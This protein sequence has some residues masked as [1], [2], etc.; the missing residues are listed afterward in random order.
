MTPGCEWSRRVE[1]HEVMLPPP[2]PQ[3]TFD[4]LYRVTPWHYPHIKMPQWGVDVPEEET[5]KT[6]ADDKFRQMWKNEMTRAGR[7]V[8]QSPTLPGARRISSGTGVVSA[9][10]LGTS[11]LALPEQYRGKEVSIY[12]T[13][14]DTARKL[15]SRQGLLPKGGTL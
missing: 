7:M 3:K 2:E 11:E 12:R 4:D 9:F 15:A 10:A 5:W 8:G 13:P 14:G 1:G 6:P